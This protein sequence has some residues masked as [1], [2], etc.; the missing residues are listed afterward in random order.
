MTS[1][2]VADP[3]PASPDMVRDTWYHGADIAA[4]FDKLVEDQWLDRRTKVPK[5]RLVDAL[6]LIAIEHAD[7]LPAYLDKLDERRSTGEGVIQ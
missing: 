5:H 4:L 6:L 3:R 1:V 7:Q 2:P